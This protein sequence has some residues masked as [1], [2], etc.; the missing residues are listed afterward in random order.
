MLG[1]AHRGFQLHDYHQHL[2]RFLGDHGYETVLCGVQHEASNPDRIGY[3]QNI[4]V[5]R[6]GTYTEMDEANSQ[7]AA[8]YLLNPHGDPFFL[9]MGLNHTHRK[10]PETCGEYDSDPWKGKKDPREGSADN[11]LQPVNWLRP[12]RYKSPCALP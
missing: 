3:R 4:T 11:Q 5:K 6:R 1:L 2:A 10:F 8:D 9:S 12:F 7:A